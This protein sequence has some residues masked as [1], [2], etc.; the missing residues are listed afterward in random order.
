MTRDLGRWLASAPPIVRL[1]A[2]VAACAL[3]TGVVLVM[4]RA[5]W[6]SSGVLVYLIA[7]LG[8][9]VLAGRAAGILASAVS[10]AAF[11]FFFVEARFSLTISDPNEWFALLTFLVVAAVT[12]Q[13]AARQRERLLDAEAGE[14]EAR[15]LHDLTDLLASGSFADA[16][17]AV[18]ERLRLELD[19]EAVSIGIAIE[20]GVSGR[21]EA[22]TAEGRAALRAVPGAMNVLS[23]GRPASASRS[24]SPGRWVRVLPAYLARGGLPRNIAHVPIRRGDDVLGQVQVKWRSATDVGAAQARLLDTA[25]DQLAVATERERL[26]TRAMEAQ[27]LRR[28]SEL[29]SALLNAVSHDLRTPLSSI[30]GAAG[31]ML[32]ADVEWRSEERREFL[33]TIEQEAA[34]LNR[35]VG[36]L[37]DL[38]RIQGG[39]LV[40][41]RDWHDPTLV[42]RETLHRL[43]AMTRE[44]R[45]VVDM[46][47]E[48]PP[49]YIDPVEI[50]QVVANLVENAVK[51]TP[52]G[53]QISVAAQVEDGELCVTVADSGPGVASEALPR[54]FEPFYRAPMTD[55]VRGSGLGLAV[56]RGLV[57]AHGGRIW[58]ENGSGRGAR[59]SFAIPSEPL[60][61]EPAP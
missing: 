58:V 17:S 29:K 53:A 25:A 45:V 60:E 46:S 8:V 55:S 10:F 31:S 22:G 40:P 14:R 5:L 7:V 41:V 33:E 42:L 18:S 43:G 49:V 54:V 57:T 2:A 16:L 13:L 48:L 38:S 19:A 35:I 37:L 32:Q 50:D 20:G 52:P 21:A 11:D 6:L 44:H 12:A 1:G 56:A 26:R 9:S 15:M 51:Y 24:G 27:V 61:V 4:P 3:A 59:F 23:E 34:R 47:D 30:I 36:N 39:T 28:T